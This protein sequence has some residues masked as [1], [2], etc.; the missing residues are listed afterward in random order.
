VLLSAVAVLYKRFL[1]GPAAV[2]S[3]LLFAVD[4]AHVYPVVWLANRSEVVSVA[5]VC[6]AI[7]AHLA[8][9]NSL[10]PGRLRAIALLLTAVGLLA[11]EHAIA[12]L[13]YLVALELFGSRGSVLERVGRLLPYLGLVAIYV[14]WRASL[15]Y[16]VA[17]SAFYVDP[18]SEP[19]R[20]LLTAATRVPLLAGDL[21]FGMAAEWWYWGVPWAHHFE[22]LLPKH[23]L[24]IETLQSV[25]VALGVVSLLAGVACL[26]WGY[27]RTRSRPRLRESWALMIGAVVSLIPLAGTASMTRLTVVPAI[28]VDAA[29]GCMLWW[30]FR[31]LVSTRGWSARLRCGAAGLLLICLHLV[32]AIYLSVQAS[33]YLTNMSHLQYGW[34]TSADFGKGD[35]RDRHVIMLSA[36]DMACQYLLPYLLHAAG[37]A[38]PLSS[39]LLSPAADNDHILTRVASNVLDIQFPEPINNP[40]FAPMVYR[41]SDPSFLPGQTFRNALFDVEVKSVRN[42]QP[43]HLRFTFHH[44]LDDRRYLF[45]YPTELGVLQLTLPSLGKSIRLDAPAWPQ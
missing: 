34:A 3:L 9:E 28:A 4:D 29:L 5:F 35:L 42:F 39:H 17:G 24:T 16:G 23:W 12:P 37:L 44:D 14:I 36:H 19:A 21:V 40:A 27:Q 25:Q 13:C 38:V 1:S 41:Q 15:G 30:L 31:K 32:R 33:L 18:F 2:L 7:W 43:R 10:H 26:S 11:G 22:G 6:W 8:A 20:Y 45:M